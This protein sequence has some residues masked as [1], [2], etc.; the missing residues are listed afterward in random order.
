[1]FMSRLE[2]F[3]GRD[4]NEP[5]LVLQPKTVTIFIGPNNGGKSAALRDILSYT[6]GGFVNGATVIHKG[7][8]SAT[9]MDFIDRKIGTHFFPMPGDS[10]TYY[11]TGNG[12]SSS[13]NYNQLKKNVEDESTDDKYHSMSNIAK[14]SALYVAGED[15]FRL[16]QHAAAGDLKSHANTTLARIFRD[17]TLQTSISRI[18]HDA[19][20][21]HLLIDHTDIGKLKYVLSDDNVADELKRA[22]AVEAGD[23]FKKCTPIENAS[24]GTRAFVGIVAEIFAGWHDIILLD[25]PEAFLHPSLAYLLGREISLNAGSQRQVFAATHSPHFLMGC[26]SAGV[27]LEIVRLTYKYGQATARSLPVETLSS[28]MRD[29]L[30]KSIGAMSALFYDNVFVTES[31]GDR[32]FYQEIEGRLSRTNGSAMRHTL[33]LNA[34]NK[35]SAAKITSVLRDVGIPTAFALDIDWIKEDGKVAQK[36]LEAAGVPEGL[37]SGLLETRRT[38][39]RYLEKHGDFKKAGGVNLLKTT[40]AVSANAFFETMEEYGLFTVRAGELESWLP[41]LEVASRKDQWLEAIFERMGAD[42]S[43]GNYLLPSTGD[44]WTFIEQVSKWVVNPNRKG[45]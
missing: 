29:P 44:V 42:P 34:H 15:R 39:R 11:F 7:A 1:M 40:E 33:F 5:P 36:Y 28:V 13:F 38:V 30:M 25:E 2:F 19:F 31:D 10:D 45:M 41:E 22:F 32:A 12:F 37:R 6:Q 4:R 20:N 21:R 23:F 16:T 24:D 17:D 8:M 26:I 43:A 18:V 14:F 27:P 3:S 9:S 35:T